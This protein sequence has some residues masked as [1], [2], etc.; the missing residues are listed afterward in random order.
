M[1]LS[2]VL[3]CDRGNEHGTCAARSW[4]ADT[5]EEAVA[6]AEAQGWLYRHSRDGQRPYSL[7]PFHAGTRP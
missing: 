6:T 2:V 3:V 1:S 4:P 5:V 7:C